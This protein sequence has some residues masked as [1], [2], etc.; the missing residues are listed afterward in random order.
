M[1][2]IMCYLGQVCQK[3]Q[4]CPHGFLTQTLMRR[5]VCCA[6][7]PEEQLERDQAEQEGRDPIMLHFKQRKDK[8]RKEQQ[9]VALRAQQLQQ[10]AAAAHTEA[11]AARA[12]AAGAGGLASA[13]FRLA[14]AAFRHL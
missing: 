1:L 13:A 6:G 7:V 3:L 5:S 10:Q 9:Q 12:L 2:Y 11:A 14:S 8:E 4:R